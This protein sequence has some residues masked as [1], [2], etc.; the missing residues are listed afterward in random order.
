MITIYIC[1]SM[2]DIAA[3]IRMFPKACWTTESLLNIGNDFS[4]YR[5]PPVALYRIPGTNE[6]TWG[7]VRDAED[8]LQFNS[9]TYSRGRLQPL[10][11][12]ATIFVTF[13]KHNNAY[14]KYVHSLNPAFSYNGDLQAGKLISQSFYWYTSYESGCYWLDLNTKWEQLLKH[15][16]IDPTTMLTDVLATV[17]EYK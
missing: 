3:F 8:Y 11:D 14:N 7:T 16:S 13:L 12:L 9:S 5:R 4:S 15:F 17:K 6:V 1:N 2:E 10:L